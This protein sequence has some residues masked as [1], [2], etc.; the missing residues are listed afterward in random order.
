MYMVRRSGERMRTDFDSKAQDAATPS[1]DVKLLLFDFR[2]GFCRSEQLDHGK[3][4]AAAAED[5]EMQ[6][7]SG[8]MGLT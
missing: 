4:S 7:S 5:R 8:A 2:A 6:H 1:D 3:P